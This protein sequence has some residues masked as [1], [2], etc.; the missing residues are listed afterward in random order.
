MFNIIKM[1]LYK[2][3]KMR[4]FYAVNIIAMVSVAIMLLSAAP[5]DFGKTDTKEENNTVVY[6]DKD[7]SVK[8]GVAVDD[9]QLIGT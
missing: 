4:S 7:Q 3:F 8:L 6:E 9:S 5:V 1:D 2:M